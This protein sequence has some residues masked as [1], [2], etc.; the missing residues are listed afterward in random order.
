MTL[1]YFK[2]LFITFIFT[3]CFHTDWSTAD[4]SSVGLAPLPEKT[5]QAIVQIYAARTFGWRGA[6]AVHT[7][8]TTK[9]KNADHYVTYHVMGYR[10]KRTGHVVVIENDIPDRKWF[11]AIPVL[12]DELTGDA[13]EKAIPQIHQ[14]AL[15]YPYAKRYSAW[16]GPNSNTFI[17]HIIRNTKELGVE[18][19]P[20]AIGKD[21]LINNDF[22]SSSESKTGF[23]FSAFGS[24]G[25]T[26][27]LAEGIELNILGLN[28]G[29]D[30]RHPALKIPFLGRIGFKDES[31]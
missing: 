3:A 31:I 13:A 27:G 1:S 29:L 10:L 20:H 25:L 8:I 17:S 24:L 14:A 9:E 5:P 28:L 23:Q 4:R 18:L 7:W 6:F 16:P 12:V 19:P 2:L 21:W 15:N 30:L 11:G 26:L 22:F